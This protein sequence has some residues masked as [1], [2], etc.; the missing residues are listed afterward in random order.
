MDKIT[1]YQKIP[2]FTGDG[3][4]AV[5]MTPEFLLS[6][7]A[8]MEAEMGLDLC[9]DF[10]RGH[11]WTEEQQGAYVEHIL[12]NGKTGRDI[13][14]NCPYWSDFRPKKGRYNDFV[15]VDGLQRITAWKAFYGDRLRVFGSLRSEFT[16][17]YPFMN[18]MR[19][20]VNDLKTKREVLQWYL[21][22][23]AGGTPHTKE[24]L[25]RVKALWEAEGKKTGPEDGLLGS[26]RR[27]G[28]P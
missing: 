4:Y 2:S 18:T 7:I 3:S 19:V 14:F 17:R 16:D 24:E 23:N 8:E 22:M 13:Y 10:Q 11:V 15:C 28:R 1:E 5:D 12:R 9:P 21:E 20:H 25:E 6:W 27:P 26:W